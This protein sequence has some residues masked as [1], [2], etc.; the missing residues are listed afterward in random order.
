MTWY[1]ILVIVIVSVLLYMLLSLSVYCLCKCSS[2]MHKRE[3]AL[4]D[5]I[6]D[7]TT[8]KDNISSKED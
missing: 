5:E 8:K 7:L 1:W 3:D 4:L 2:D 6:R